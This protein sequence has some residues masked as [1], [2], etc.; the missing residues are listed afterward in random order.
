MATDLFDAAGQRFNV[1]PNLLRAVFQTE[2][3][4]SFGTPDSSAGA[5]GGM[6]VMPQTY[7]TVAQ[8]Y[9]LG[10]DPRNPVNNVMAGAAV[11]SENLGQYGNVPDA[12]RA[13]NAGSPS[14]WNNPQTAAY[15]GKVAAAYAPLAS[16][17]SSPSGAPDSSGSMSAANPPGSYQVASANTGTA[18]D[19]MPDPDAPPA[20][21]SPF[22][23]S[24][25][26]ASPVSL[27]NDALH[28]LLTGSAGAGGSA[29]ASATA[30]PPSSAPAG[31][32]PLSD[33][34]LH[35]MLTG[36]PSVSQAAPA[37]TLR[38]SPPAPSLQP[39]APSPS[40]GLPQTGF[41]GGLTTVGEGIAN[42]AN[43]FGAYV[44]Q[45][46]PALGALD[47][48]TLP[49]IGLNQP[50]QETAALTPDIAARDQANRGS[51]AYTGGKI[52]GDIAATAPVM[53]AGG[54]LAGAAGGALDAAPVVG[55]LLTGAGNVARALPGGN[56]LLGL[57]TRGATGALQG[58]GAAAL[59]SGQ[60]SEP[61][62]QQ[63]EQG[64]FLGGGL[65]VVASPLINA[66]RS[67][68]NAVKGGAISPE[69]AQL[70][71]LAQSTYNI[72]ITAAQISESP[73][74]R[75]A[76]S[77]AG[78]VPFSG[79][80]GDQA[81]TQTAFNQA[82]A[83]TI[84]ESATKITPAVMQAARTRLGNT[85]D[86]IAG[87]SFQADDQLVNDL[88]GIESNAQL[89]LPSAE[90]K[91]ISNQLDNVLGSVDSSG[92]IS[93]DAYQVLTRQGAQLDRAQSSSDPNVSFY[94]GQVRDALDDALAR[95]IPPDQQAAL[96]QARSQW[97][98]LKTIEPLAAKSP[99]GDISPPALMTPVKMSY[100][101]IAYTGG[102][103]LG[104]L[105]R[106]GQLIREPPSSGTGD[107]GSGLMSLTGLGGSA[108]TTIAGITHPADAA[109][110]VGAALGG[111][112][113]ARGVT[114]YL[115][116]PIVTNSLIRRGLAGNPGPGP[117][118]NALTGSAVPL[119]TLAG[120]KLLL[121][122]PQRALPGP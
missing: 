68:V 96:L 111:A 77:A 98:A 101:N 112:G 43:R 9:G 60:S 1:D 85:F 65:G 92:N 78:R 22:Q 107:S 82:V 79:A 74:V 44:D 114:S 58:A 108:A 48:S 55:N 88:A 51:L 10:S 91:P 13:Y 70:A 47:R 69:T 50:A 90:W 84:G 89:V 66:A 122:Q 62:G 94:A 83:N 61:I 38:V 5:M 116:S 21:L 80:S 2:S 8:R 18:T 100:G 39:G 113:L 64:A 75:F 3:G 110:T 25:S 17:S 46:V 42:A 20:T 34:A 6:Q 56:T 121:G 14:R 36:S 23:G 71:N 30:N 63:L 29:G 40:A 35:S 104:D 109:Y 99:T 119:G 4:G 12:L 118:Q 87:H 117:I 32:M 76:A 52:A 41:M 15:V 59:T 28:A 27:S 93:G 33:D 54:A 37:A 95:G 115:G 19:A 31:T 81:A 45:N 49:A 86:T 53:A 73:G 72:P 106:I 102:G 26:P 16:S 24:S 103:P 105:A 120:Q 7:A 57:A 97:K 11:L 67:I